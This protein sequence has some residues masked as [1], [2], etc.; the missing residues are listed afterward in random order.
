MWEAMNDRANACSIEDVS[1]RDL[2][3]DGAEFAGKLENLDQLSKRSR[4]LS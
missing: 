2:A 1:P 3:P 4:S